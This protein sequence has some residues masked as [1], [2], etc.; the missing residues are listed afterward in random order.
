EMRPSA[1]LILCVGIA[2]PGKSLPGSDGSGETG[3]PQTGAEGDLA[4]TILRL[5]GWEKTTESPQTGAPRTAKMS[6]T[7]TTTTEEPSTAEAAATTEEPTT[8]STTPTTTTEEPE[9]TTTKKI[10]VC[11]F[12]S[13]PLIMSGD[14]AYCKPSSVGDCPVGFLCDQS[15]VLGRSICCRDT[16]PK[17]LPVQSFQS[18]VRPPFSWNT[19]TPTAQTPKSAT[20]KKAPWYVKDRTPWR[21]VNKPTSAPL[22]SV[23]EKPVKRVENTPNPT[24]AEPTTTPSTT[25]TE[26]TTTTT[27]EEPT[28]TTTAAATT[29]K[30][31]VPNPW[32]SLWTSTV[33]PRA[34]VNVS[35]LQTGNIR[36]LKDSQLE[37]VGTIS[38]IND[39]GFYVLV[40]TGAAADT[41][42]LLHNRPPPRPTG[43]HQGGALLD[44]VPNDLSTLVL[45]LLAQFTGF[46]LLAG[47]MLVIALLLDKS[48]LLIPLIL[49]KLLLFLALSATS[50]VLG[51]ALWFRFEALVTLVLHRTQLDDLDERPGIRMAALIMITASAASAMAELWL[52]IVLI[53]AYR[54]W[55]DREIEQE[56]QKLIREDVSLEQ[57]NTVVIT[58]A[59]PGH[60]G[61]MNF[62]AQKPVLFH[63]M[64]YIGRHATPTELKER[65]YRK[66]SANVEV[67]KTPGHTQHDLTVL[68]HNVAGYGTMAIA[69]DLIPN[70]NLIAEKRD[71]MADEGVWDSAIKRQNANLI[72]CMAD[73]IVPGHG[74][75][76]RVLAHYR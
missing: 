11:P 55:T 62:F 44:R 50:L 60:V 46:L 61:N 23:P 2:L 6:Q 24:T 64:E 20:T 14:Y 17:V 75:P 54:Q 27:T 53:R 15:F 13:E 68:V 71:D 41:E 52:L 72:V 37:M 74:Q 63:S 9:T 45:V 16:R 35:V 3:T 33:V 34:S 1:Y 4:S 66:I 59:H 58:H 51:W 49:L 56:A 31:A 69:G 26:T 36:H 7:T 28:T 73:W 8:P 38:L 76:F 29:T 48:L 65:P 25:T 19:V 22:I 21:P 39:N 10:E 42:R 43:P 18:T 30:K 12:N 47:I 57:I 67:W 40:D 70:E 5:F 32:S